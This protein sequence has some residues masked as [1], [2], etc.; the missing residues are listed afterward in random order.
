MVAAGVPIWA[1]VFEAFAHPEGSAAVLT[2]RTIEL[3]LSSFLLAGT[4]T[5]LA[6]LLGV[7]LGVALGLGRIPG[8][9]VWLTL[10]ALPM[11][12]PPLLLALGWFHLLG[13]EGV[14]GNAKTSEWLFSR[15]GLVFVMA[16]TL[17]PFVTLCTMLGARG[18]E[19]ALVDAA[20]LTARPLTVAARIVVPLAWPAI[21][22]GALLVFTLSFAEV[23]VPMFLRVQ[24]YPA[25]VFARLGGLVFAPTEAAVLALPVVLLALLIVVVERVVLRRRPDVLSSRGGEQEPLRL[26]ASAWLAYLLVGV[27]VTL[28]L[29]PLVGLFVRA[30][31]ES[32]FSDAWARLGTTVENSLVVAATAASAAALLATVIGHGLARGSKLARWLDAL[33]LAAF[34]TPA[35]VTGVGAI[36]AWNR[37]A[38]AWLY[39]TLAILSLCL[40]GRYA[41]VAIRVFDAGVRQ[42]PPSHEE[43]AAVSGAGYLRRLIGVVV[44]E[45]WRSLV[46][47]WLLCMVFCL[48]DVETAILVYPPGGETLPVRIFT[49]E[50]NGPVSTVA[51]LALFHVA[52]TFVALAALAA[53][54]RP[55]RIA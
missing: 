43:A 48:R 36:V 5:I 39:G 27:G 11:F 12:L 52:L 22:V 38:T 24:V 51:A 10:H 19:P 44:P 33:A 34:L 30:V 50:A 2:G 29:M 3:F 37:P 1:V 13:R 49:L 7:P 32:G 20:R 31:R 23:A 17:T 40:L 42:R 14:L 55:R 47:A 53:V 9:R 41:V 18:I 46:A 6:L 8:R 45:T 16:A 21:A 26:G 15:P 25:T 54:V 4:V 35:A 28:S